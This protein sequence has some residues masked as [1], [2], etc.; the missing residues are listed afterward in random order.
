MRNQDN[1]P[2]ADTLNVPVVLHWFLQYHRHANHPD[3]KTRI[4]IWGVTGWMQLVVKHLKSNKSADIFKTHSN[5]LKAG[6]TLHLRALATQSSR[7][8][9]G[10]PFLGK[11]WEFDP[12]GLT[13]CKPL[14]W[15]SQIHKTAHSDN[16]SFVFQMIWTYS[17]ALN[18]QDFA[19]DATLRKHL[20]RRNSSFSQRVEQIWYQSGHVDL[21]KGL[22]SGC[23][24]SKE[25]REL[26]SFTR[27]FSQISRS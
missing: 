6:R 10:R 15:L 12:K 3:Y 8:C 17:R 26:V 24:F 1:K 22:N 23:T 5:H 27:S 2:V 11:V 18:K 14:S 13:S 9:K 20:T 7:Y 16:S 19:M 25:G 4:H 21:L